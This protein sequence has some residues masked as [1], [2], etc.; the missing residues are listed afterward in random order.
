[1]STFS[2]TGTLLSSTNPFPG[3]NGPLSVATG[4]VNHD[5]TLDLIVATL[6]GSSHVKVFS[7]TDGSLLYSFFAFPGFSGGASVAAGDVNGDGFADIVVG[8]GPGGS[9]HMKVFS[10]QDGSLLMSFFAYPGYT[11]AVSVA[12]ADVNGDGHADIVTGSTGDLTNGLFG[13]YTAPSHVKV[14]SGLDG[15]VLQ[16]FYAFPGTTGGVNVAAGDL[17]GSGH[18]EIVVGAANGSSQVATFDGQTGAQLLSFQAFTGFAGGVRVGVSGRNIIAGAGPGAG[19]HVKLFDGAV[20][21]LQQSFYA[22]DPVF[23]SGVFVG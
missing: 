20:G 2:L 14:F 3:Y 4:D 11:G 10:G 13:A 1:V 19:P 22:F 5:G 8:A 9:G 15:S 18:A 23:V 6:I 16:S 17:T 7:G 21:T 12:A